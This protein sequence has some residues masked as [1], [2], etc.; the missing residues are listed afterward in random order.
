MLAKKAMDLAEILFISFLDVIITV[1]R[2]KKDVV[3]RQRAK[4]GG[5][6]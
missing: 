6:G 1:D 4:V 2:I 5:L 3:V